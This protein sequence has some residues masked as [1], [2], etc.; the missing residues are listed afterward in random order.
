MKLKARSETEK[1]KIT[2][3]KIDMALAVSVVGCHKSEV[4]L[5]VNTFILSTK[6]K[7]NKNMGSNKFI[8]HYNRGVISLYNY[9]QLFPH[10]FAKKNAAHTFHYNRGVISLSST[11]NEIVFADSLNLICMRIFVTPHRK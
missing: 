6:Q 1:K 3:I 11:E 5:S 7:A 10:Y 4:I 2:G 9:I 8:F